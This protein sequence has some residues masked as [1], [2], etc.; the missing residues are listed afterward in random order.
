[1]A[2]EGIPPLPIGMP[3]VDPKTGAASREFAQWWQQLFGNTQTLE[4]EKV[5]KGNVADSGLTMATDRLLGRD[6]AGTGAIEELTLSQALD[7]IG[8]AAQGDILYRGAA[9]WERLGAGTSGEFLQTLGAG[10]DPQWAAAS[11]GGGI[12]AGAQVVKSADQTAANFTAAT[13]LSWDSEVYDTSGFHDNAV[14]NTRLTIPAGVSKVRLTANITLANVT[15]GVWVNAFIQKNGAGFQGRARVNYD[16]AFTTPSINLTTS[17]VDVV[18]GDY[19]EVILQVETDTSID[20]IAATSDFSIEVVSTSFAG[21]Q[22]VK[23]ADQTAANYTAITAIAWDSEVYD[24]SSF[25]DNAVNNTRITIPAGVSKVRLT[26]NITL[27]SVTTGVWVV[28]SILKNGVVFQGRPRVG[29]DAPFTTPSLN[30]MTS[31]VDVVAGDYFEVFLLVETDTSITVTASASD[32]SVEVV[33]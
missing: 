29:Y 1:M 10:A 8:S 12:F 33:A 14:N 28:A 11:G 21:A 4:D 27:A 6:T 17:V 20:V 15:A 7:F 32:F 3:I 2:L 24:T 16:A 22:V 18:A 5:A 31:I 19:F 9:N 30:L 13:A 23:A 26:A 25:H